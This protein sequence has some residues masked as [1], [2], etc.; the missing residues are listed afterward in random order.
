M[1]ALVKMALEKLHPLTE[2]LFTKHG[3]CLSKHGD[4]SDNMIIVHFWEA[5]RPW[6]AWI[7]M[8]EPMT[9]S[10]AFGISPFLQANFWSRRALFCR[11]SFENCILMTA[12][13]KMALEK[14]HP[15]TEKLFTKHG[16]CLSKHGDISDNMII[17]SLLRS[18]TTIRKI[19]DGCGGAIVPDSPVACG[20]SPSYRQI[21]GNGHCFFNLIQ[22][23]HLKLSNYLPLHLSRLFEVIYTIAPGA[24]V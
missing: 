12:L 7:T 8:A 15:L 13:V 16:H 6:M 23:P 24:K 14:L 22:N 1:T 20:K 11:N 3:H 9:L 19:L 17:V 5:G 21:L 18:W 4:I 2:K 10:V